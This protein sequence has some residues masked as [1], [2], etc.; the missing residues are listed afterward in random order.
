MR[1]EINHEWNYEQPPNEVWEYLTKAELITLWLMPNNF[2]PIIGHEFQ[3][4]TKAMPT[5]DLDGIFHCKVLEIEPYRKLSYS[6]KGG[7]GNGVFT[8]DTIC[9]WHLEPC[10]NG[11]KLKLKHSGF[12]E[13]NADIFIGMTNGWQQNIRKMLNYIDSK[14]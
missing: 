4:Q 7:P 12:R 9:E 1:K 14:K 10:K 6:W 11:S 5:L 3:F 2:K 8:L 13:H